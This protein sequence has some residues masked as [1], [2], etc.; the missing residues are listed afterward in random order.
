ML[1]LASTPAVDLFIPSCPSSLFVDFFLLTFFSFL[2]LRFPHCLIVSRRS[3]QS[4]LRDG[5]YQDAVNL[6]RER[7]LQANLRHPNIVGIQDSFQD[8]KFVYLVLDF[9]SGGDV[10]KVELV[11]EERRRWPFRDTLVPR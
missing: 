3:S 5:N 2:S 7:R 10:Y 1:S 6:D 4:S 8:P 9:A 11:H